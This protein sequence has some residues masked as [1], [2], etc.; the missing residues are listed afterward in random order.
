MPTST[1][2][3]LT[4]G[5]WLKI[6]IHCM[7]NFPH[8]KHPKRT[9][10]TRKDFAERL[11]E[12]ILSSEHPHVVYD[13]RSRRWQCTHCQLN[14]LTHP[15]YEHLRRT[16]H[17]SGML[18]VLAQGQRL[19][20]P[21]PL[22][23]QGPPNLHRPRPPRTITLNGRTTDPSHR[24]AYYRGL[25]VCMR[26]GHLAHTEVHKLSEA[27]HA[28]KATGSSNLKRLRADKPPYHIL[29][30]FNGW[31]QVERQAVP[32]NILIPILSRSQLRRQ[33]PLPGQPRAP[34]ESPIWETT[35]GFDISD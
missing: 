18:T 27:C 35:L 30:K 23:Q 2:S 29:K 26:C 6:N 15:M 19:D 4:K 9:P 14:L 34:A 20:R 28:P 3:K 7:K 10:A 24:L 32:Q 21:I 8:P 16:R 11:R 25:Y 33:I 13:D 1:S 22:F 5:G 12:L 31:P 17:C